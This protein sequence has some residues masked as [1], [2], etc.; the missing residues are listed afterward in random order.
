MDQLKKLIIR[1]LA[2]TRATTH[3]LASCRLSS[4]II[5]CFSRLLIRCVTRI[6]L[7]IIALGVYISSEMAEYRCFFYILVS[8]NYFADKKGKSCCQTIHSVLL[9]EQFEPIIEIY[10]Q[11][12]P[13]Y[14]FLSAL[15]SGLVG[16]STF[17]AQSSS[18]S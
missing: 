8:I 14:H 10:E 18:I 13:T 2:T 7:L 16:P 3:A 4:T 17:F 5:R 1:L 6:L 9:R 12:M 15:Y 11:L